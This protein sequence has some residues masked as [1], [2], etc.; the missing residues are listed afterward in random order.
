MIRLIRLI[1]GG[2]EGKY[3]LDNVKESFVNQ[4]YSLKRCYIV[5]VLPHSRLFRGLIEV[6]FFSS[7]L[8]LMMVQ[9]RVGVK[10]MGGIFK[11]ID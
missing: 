11:L 5:D 7:S 9:R 3:V 1:W 2:G 6:Y 4:W 8:I 10:Q